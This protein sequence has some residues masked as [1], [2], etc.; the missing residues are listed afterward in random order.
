MAEY[1]LG[2][3]K[4]LGS[5]V[6]FKMTSKGGQ[7]TSASFLLHLHL[8]FT[9]QAT[10]SSPC[11]PIPLSFEKLESHGSVLLAILAEPCSPSHCLY[12]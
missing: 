2:I 12:L 3:Q 8:P 4:A 9:G 7:D 6:T 1:G 5:S 11:E 10:A